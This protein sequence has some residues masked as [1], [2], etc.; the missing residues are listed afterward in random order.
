VKH[1]TSSTEIGA[2]YEQDLEIRDAELVR[3]AMR[4]G[5]IALS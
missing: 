1:R 5:E 4:T 3:G 2:R